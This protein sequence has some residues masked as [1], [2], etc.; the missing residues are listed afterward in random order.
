MS[1]NNLAIASVPIQKR[2]ELYNEVEALNIGTIFYDLN[3]PFFAAEAVVGSK[4]PIAKES[5]HQNETHSE[6]EEL[7]TKI[8]QIGFYLDDLTLYLDTHETDIQ[9]IQLYHQRVKEYAELRTQFAQQY[10]PLTR[11]CIPYCMNGNETDFCWQNGPI[12]W[13]GA[14]I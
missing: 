11:L 9:A 10:Y 8:T 2:G 13:E 3:K 6:R 12:P 7:M 14:C 1:D 5:G 4:S